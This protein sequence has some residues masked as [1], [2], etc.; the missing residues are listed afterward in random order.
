[1]VWTSEL[2]IHMQELFHFR[3]NFHQSRGYRDELVKISSLGSYNF[4]VTIID[5]II[6]DCRFQYHIY[7]SMFRIHYLMIRTDLISQIQVFFKC[8]LIPSNCSY[9]SGF[10]ILKQVKK[11]LEDFGINVV[12]RYTAE[13][14][15]MS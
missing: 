2:D 11:I 9:Y 6:F 1:M 15:N 8:H 5:L 3:L 10:F 14:V 12:L 13:P 7:K 4:L